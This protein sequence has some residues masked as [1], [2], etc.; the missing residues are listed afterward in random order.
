M[1]ERLPSYRPF[2]EWRLLHGNEARLLFNQSILFS[3]YQTDMITF[4]AFFLLCIRVSF[5]FTSRLHGESQP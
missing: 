3:N 2:H 4:L 1:E 5:D